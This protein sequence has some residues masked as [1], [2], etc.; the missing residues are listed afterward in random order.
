[1]EEAAG[2]LAYFA[3]G[4]CLWFRGQ[5][6]GGLRTKG[7]IWNGVVI[8]SANKIQK[9]DAVFMKVKKSIILTAVLLSLGSAGCGEELFRADAENEKR[10]EDTA[11]TGHDAPEQD[12]PE[13]FEESIDGV[14][15]D[16]DIRISEEADMENLHTMTATLQQPDIEKAKAVFAE[17]KTIVDEQRE[18]GSGENGTE[19][20]CYTADYEDDTFLN[21]STN[22][23]YSHTPV[24]E[25]INGAFR[26]YSY[27]NAERYAKDAVLKA[28]NPEMIFE[29]VLKDIRDA[30]YELENAAYDYYALDYETMAEEFMMLDKTGEALSTEG[31]SWGVEDEC[32]FYTAVQLQEGLPVYFGSQ[33]FPEDEE[34]SR[35]IQVLCS[36]N[37]LERLD[38]SRL[39]SFSKPGDAV[40]LLNLDTIVKTVSKKYADI[41]GPSFTVKRAELYKMP[42]KSADSTYDVK[43][44]WLFEVLETGND[45]D[46]GEKYEYTQYMFVDAVDGT[47]VLI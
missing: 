19:F 20:P 10:A 43:I 16:M 12:F 46:T 11:Q 17:G 44:V 40:S 18:T 9:G 36:A 7:T 41:I 26:L 1:M 6:S 4:F 31:I 30:G 42:V 22:L 14:A 8:L 25:K 38:I 27:Y 35:P 23:T 47:E 3:H 33:D 21:I 34:S 32:Y 2:F 24:F 45:S 15:F 28:G 29:R 39:Y 5:K 13:R 37:G